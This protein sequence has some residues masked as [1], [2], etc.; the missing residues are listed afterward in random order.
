MASKFVTPG[1]GMPG[2]PGSVQ[3]ALTPEGQGRLAQQGRVSLI[4]VAALNAALAG[5]RSVIMQSIRNAVKASQRTANTPVVRLLQEV[6]NTLPTSNL[7][8]RI[9]QAVGFAGP[10]DDV[11]TAYE[12][13]FAA[14][15]THMPYR[16]I[17]LTDLTAETTA[18]TQLVVIYFDLAT[19]PNWAHDAD[20]VLLIKS[21]GGIV[22]G[23]TGTISYIDN[24][25]GAVLGT[26][27]GRNV[28]PTQV[29]TLNEVCYGVMDPNSNEVLFLPSCCM[30]A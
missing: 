4:V 26:G 16:A 6:V 19:S 11:Q 2:K 3:A 7:A 20:N 1:H 25:T 22:A 9:Y 29:S 28:H 15:P 10:Q 5:Q 21:D 18:Q 8:G 13:Y 30:V 24:D 14:N 23:D 27:V 12:A 17:D